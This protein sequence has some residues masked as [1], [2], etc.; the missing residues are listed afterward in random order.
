MS[1]QH[2]EVIPLK[3]SISK[4]YSILTKKK[5][6]KYISQEYRKSPGNVETKTNTFEALSDL[7]LLGTLN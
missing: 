1:S 4:Q 5:K 3:Q 2:P 6:K 7:L